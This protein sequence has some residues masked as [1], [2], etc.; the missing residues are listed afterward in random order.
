M[1]RRGVVT[2]IAVALLAPP[3]AAQISPG[4][5]SKA[6]RSLEGSGHCGTCHDPKLGLAADKCLSCHRLLAT[7][8]AAGKGLHGRA[9]HRDCKIC[10]VDHQGL[11][12][13]LVWW[14]KAGRQS[15]DHATTGVALVGKHRSLKCEACHQSRLVHL[16]PEE[17]KDGAVSIERTYLGLGTACT[18]CHV[19]EH[20]GQFKDAACESCHGQDAWKPAA[21][22]DHAR[23][24]FPLSGRHAAVAC[25]KCHATLPGT[26]RRNFKSALGHDCVSCHKD[27]HRERLGSDCARC[28][29][30]G[31]WQT[32]ATKQFDHERTGYA[33]VG[34][35]TATDCAKCHTTPAA[36][37][38]AY[39]TTA[40]REC[41]GCHKDVHGGRYGAACA[42]CHTPEAWKT[43]D[44]Q[45]FDHDR[46]SYPLR[47]RHA[48]VACAACHAPDRPAKL[49]HEACADCHRDPHQGQLAQ[50]GDKGACESCHGVD[51]FKPARFDLA[52]HALTS[53]A[54]TGAH[55]A[56]PCDACHPPLSR[57]GG[58]G[59]SRFRYASTRCADCHRDPHQ[60]DLA[61]YVAEGGCE[62][63]HK[64]ES[65][66]ALNFDHGKTRLA[67]VAAHA[68]TTCAEC[69]KRIEVGTPRERV[70]FANLP[71]TCDG[72][73]GDWHRGQFTPPTCDRCHL[74]EDL[75]AARFDHERD[76][77]FHLAGAHAKL[78]CAACHPAQKDGTKLTIRY[79]PLAKDCKDCHKA[80]RDPGKVGAP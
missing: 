62:S 74:S 17:L 25:D 14:G 18:S 39:A 49:R 4:P 41:A 64:T 26:T 45:R 16:S 35:H 47:G 21:G 68:R 10:H 15:F 12:A 59:N 60:G 33:L 43:G 80:P 77:A 69:H 71:L 57:T 73:H 3:A 79:K 38:P 54:L 76:A 72:C 6:H 34:K 32:Y 29:E 40:S 56:V 27:P 48:A 65:W 7:R 11:E 52:E 78:A 66:R 53:Y 61:R 13:A 28:H 36:T 19:D 55:L 44:R 8:V 22:F 75:S 5:L 24:S 63:C 67:L 58:P 2:L 50:R 37:G 31:D 46:T 70:Q 23:T 20:R 51:G 42:T 30:T 9:D 1:K